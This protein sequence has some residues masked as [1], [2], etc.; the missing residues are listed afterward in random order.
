MKRFNLAII[1][2]MTVSL[3]V[4]PG[5]G[6]RGGNK[7]ERAGL[8]PVELT[9]WRVF[10]GSD[11]FTKVID[12]YRARHPNVRINYRKLRFD[13]YQD[14]L[15]Q[16]FAEDR[17]PDMFSVHNTWMKGYLPLIEP[18]PDSVRLSYTELQ[19]T[20]KKE[21]VV[22][23]RNEPTLSL[24]SLTDQF[25][26]VVPEYVV[27]PSESEGAVTNKIHGLPLSVDTLALFYN[28]DILD[29]AGL[30]QPPSTWEQ[31]QEQVVELTKYDAN[32]DVAQ[33][34]AA[35]GY[36][37]NVERSSDII[38]LLM[39]QS[40]A[41]MTDS[42]G[43]ARFAEVPSGASQQS[44]PSLEATRFYT[45]FANPSKEVY[46]WDPS[47]PNSFDAFAAGQTAFF[48]GYSYHMPSIKARAPK[49]NFAVSPMPQISTDPRSQINFANFWIETVSKKTENVDW[50]W[51]FVQFAAKEKYVSAF[52]KEA[53]RPTALRSVV[54]EQRED[55]DLSV[56]VDQVLSAQAW[57]NGEDA[58]ASENAMEKMLDDIVD[59]TS[60]IGEALG[61]AQQ[62][63]N[64]TL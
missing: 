52:L 32:G 33:S 55:F 16:A 35:F 61:I 4:L 57:Y 20:L 24:R 38:S 10:D 25:V 43:T 31:F 11:T 12:S 22:V 36:G 40:G 56:F 21:S 64:Q 42:R 28:K 48:F 14:E 13:E 54:L 23:V 44:L 49:L 51:D 5:L 1:T 19:G 63:V 39:M 59:G 62:Q 47:F 15:L 30:P 18:L 27:Y 50:A 46:T 60:E 45:D 8:Q 9:Y 7:E 34:A 2:L 17:G 26:S 29:A 58:T 37:S 41:T 3:V 6:C 53:G